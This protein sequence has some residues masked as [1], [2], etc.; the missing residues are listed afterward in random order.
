MTSN[1][2]GV[3]LEGTASRT[4]LQNYDI[5]WRIFGAGCSPRYL[6]GEPHNFLGDT[7]RGGSVEDMNKDAADL[8]R[9]ARVSRKFSDPALRRLWATL[10]G[11]TPLFYLLAPRSISGYG[12][13]DAFSKVSIPR[14]NNCLIVS[15]LMSPVVWQ[16]LKA[17]LWNDADRWG[18]FQY[19]AR[20]VHKVEFY[21]E[22][23]V[24]PDLQCQ[25]A[26]VLIHRIWR[27]SRR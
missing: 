27:I 25:L 7:F 11:I 14:P 9:W 8:A 24:A 22:F 19:Y 5:L 21:W 15:H 6:D 16:I 3:A 10:F 12:L 20:L 13:D 4:A 23:D 2:I 1:N 26:H 17:Q 18:R